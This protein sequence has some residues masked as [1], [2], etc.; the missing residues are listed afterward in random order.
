M[1]TKFWSENVQER[2]HVEYKDLYVRISRMGA[3]ELYLF[4]SE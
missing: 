1:R 4:G 3:G 2:G